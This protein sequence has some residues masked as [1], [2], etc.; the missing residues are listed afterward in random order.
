MRFEREEWAT[1]TYVRMS[2]HQVVRLAVTPRFLSRVGLSLQP[3]NIDLPLLCRHGSLS[4]PTQALQGTTCQC[5]TRLQ[6][7]RTLSHGYK[8]L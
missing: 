6:P 5:C 7:T 4:A 8:N 2:G 3:P 1:V